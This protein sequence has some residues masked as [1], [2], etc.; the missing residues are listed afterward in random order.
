MAGKKSSKKTTKKTKKIS[1]SRTTKL[2]PKK[3]VKAV[4]KKPMKK[5][6]KS[7]SIRATKRKIYLVLTKLMLF[8][9]LSL[10]SFLLY[11]FL[12]NEVLKNLFLL[13]AM[14][15]GFLAVAFLIILLV[16]LILKIMKK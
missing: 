2:T 5:L 9:V 15:L 13:L 14:I 12:G 6:K 7:T 10:A 16:F 1:K 11:F 3:S 4:I 8:A